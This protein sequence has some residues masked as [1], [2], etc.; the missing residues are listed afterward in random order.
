MS[1]A[2]RRFLVVLRRHR[3]RSTPKLHVSIAPPKSIFLTFA[4]HDV[5]EAAVDE[6]DA[7]ALG[8]CEVKSGGDVN[9]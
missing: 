4:V 3:P 5:L 7:A 1:Q 8:F 2:D 6:H 9:C